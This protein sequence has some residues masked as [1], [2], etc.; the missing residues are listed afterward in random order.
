[1]SDYQ[2]GY[3]AAANQAAHADMVRTIFDA[4]SSGAEES[5]AE[6]WCQE[7]HRQ[8]ARARNAEQDLANTEARV[9]DLENQ[10]AKLRGEVSCG[11]RIIEGLRKSIKDS[12]EREENIAE[13]AEALRCEANQIIQGLDDKVEQH[14]QAANKWEANA[15]YAQDAHNSLVAEYNAAI[16]VLKSSS[17]M[18]AGFAA[19]YRMLALE[20]MRKHDPATFESLDQ[21]KRMSVMNEAWLAFIQGEQ[22][23]YSPDLTFSYSEP[24]PHADN[25]SEIPYHVIAED[26]GLES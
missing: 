26:A 6:A 9:A 4:F 25:S 24:I 21:N 22:V 3:Q 11:D 15:R 13:A 10:V 1:M 16:Q 14:R 5:S 19:I 2:R 23:Q 18:T 20:V 8:R 12:R 7:A 17:A